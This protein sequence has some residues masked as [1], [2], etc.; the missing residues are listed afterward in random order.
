MGPSASRSRR[1]SRQSRPVPTHS[2]DVRPSGWSGM[3]VRFSRPDSGPCADRCADRIVTG[4]TASRL[5]HRPEECRLGAESSPC[6]ALGYEGGA[7]LYRGTATASWRRILFARFRR[8]RNSV[9]PRSHSPVHLRG[10]SYDQRQRSPFTRRSV[11][12]AIVLV[13]GVGLEPTR[14]TGPNGFSS[15]YGFRRDVSWTFSSPTRRSPSSLCTVPFGLG[16]GLP[17]Y[18]VP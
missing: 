4:V 18:R 10:S 16:S 12:Y 7:I 13:P 11:H 1:P 8:S 14:D 17:S 9:P 15:H 6:G 3:P 2:V 5:P